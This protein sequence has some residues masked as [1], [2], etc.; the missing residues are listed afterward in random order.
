LTKV[1][2][3]MDSIAKLQGLIYTDEN[4]NSMDVGHQVALL[5]EAKSTAKFYTDFARQTYN[6]VDFVSL[7]SEIVESQ[8]RDSKKISTDRKT[9]EIVVD[10]LSNETDSEYKLIPWSERKLETVEN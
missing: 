2:S 8:P 7:Q 6:D 5:Q 3:V 1:Q 4:L 9:T 10:V